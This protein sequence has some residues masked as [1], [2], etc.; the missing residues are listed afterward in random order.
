MPLPFSARV[1]IRPGA[2]SS[3]PIESTGRHSLPTALA[4]PTISIREKQNDLLLI[5]SGAIKTLALE[6]YRL[7]VA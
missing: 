3:L 1:P 5:L 7:V 6:T 4:A 2:Q